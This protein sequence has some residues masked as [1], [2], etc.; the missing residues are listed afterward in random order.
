MPSL[1]DKV[2]KPGKS[3]NLTGYDCTNIRQ[4]DYT[5]VSLLATEQ[6][7]LEEPKITSQVVNVQILQSK[8]YEKVKYY[9]AM[10]FFCQSSNV[11][12]GDRA[13]ILQ[14]NSTTIYIS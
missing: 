8:N 7:K 4:T 1:C 2:T 14:R 9:S 13:E 10:F 11:E 12:A 5:I 3:R 6:C